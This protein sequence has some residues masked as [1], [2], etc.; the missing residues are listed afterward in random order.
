MKRRLLQ[1]P[2]AAVCSSWT[3]WWLTSL[4]S[5]SAM[6]PA[7]QLGRQLLP[8]QCAVQPSSSCWWWRQQQSREPQEQQHRQLQTRQQGRRQPWS[9]PWLQLLLN[10][11]VVQSR[12]LG[13]RTWCGLSG[14]QRCRRSCRRCRGKGSACRSRCSR[15]RRQ[16][17]SCFSRQRSSRERRSGCRRSSRLPLRS[18]VKLSPQGWRMWNR[19]LLIVTSCWSQCSSCKPSCSPARWRQPRQP[20]RTRPSQWGCSWPRRSWSIKHRTTSGWQ[21]QWRG[22]VWASPP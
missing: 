20:T 19:P 14:L 21:P 16:W 18:C 12:Q 2:P 4:P 1:P 5:C 9:R 11:S 10:G 17:N 6:Q 22:V 3:S 13:R 8:A 7:W 15:C